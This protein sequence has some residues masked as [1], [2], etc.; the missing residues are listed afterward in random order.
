MNVKIQKVSKEI[1]KI[2]KKI[3]EF[4]GKLRELEK[5]KTE[6]E[7]LDIVDAVRS[8]NIPLS[9]LVEVLKKQRLTSGQIGPKSS[10]TNSEINKEENK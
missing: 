8:S 7:N 10:S 2:K 3:N 1:D 9:D 6:L 4:Q 5:Q